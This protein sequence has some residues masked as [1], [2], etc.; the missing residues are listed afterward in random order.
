M[1]H[2]LNITLILIGIFLLSQIVGLI[3][4]DRY[5]G[6]R[7]VD[8]ETG[9]VV[10][11]TY[12]DLPLNIDRPDV[13]ESIS[14]IF[15]LAAILLGTILVLLLVK[16]RSVRIWKVWFFI[17]VS[18]CL[19][20]AFAAF[21][22]SIIAIAGAILVATLKIYK[23]NFFIHNASEVFIYGGLAAIFVPIMNLFAIVIL[24]LIISVYDMFAV[25]KSK[26]MVKMAKFQTES[27]VFAGISIPY[28]PKN[29]K[30]S[31]VSKSKK[32]HVKK[33]EIKSAILGGGDIGFP[34]LFAG[35]L[36]KAHGFWKVLIIPVV[37]SI[38]LFILLTLAK[39][40]RFY[41]AMPF[42][43]IACFAGYGILLLL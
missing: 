35:V 28:T 39:K 4:T 42:V 34:L 22:P 25:W 5:I 12:N 43:T 40:N 8:V 38:S 26:H 19:T 27:K 13:E 10:N 7:I 41:P 1:K 30:K 11:I 24:L 16:F 23:P 2:T 9:E 15:I 33:E 36:M 17:S 29:N 32:M 3:I 31:H 6:D 14:F 20:V 21:L 18:V 37:V